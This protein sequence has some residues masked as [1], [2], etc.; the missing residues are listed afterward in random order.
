MEDTRDL[1]LGLDDFI[2]ATLR[3]EIRQIQGIE[4]D[5]DGDGFVVMRAVEADEADQ[6]KS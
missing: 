1:M 5:E 6:L 2:R 3:D 4:Q